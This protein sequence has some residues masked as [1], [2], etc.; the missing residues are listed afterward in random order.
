M[1]NR[2]ANHLF[3]IIWDWLRPWKLRQISQIPRKTPIAD[4]SEAWK[5]DGHTHT[6][7]SPQTLDKDA[8][9]CDVAIAIAANFLP[10]GTKTNPVEIMGRDTEFVGVP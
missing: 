6:A 4:P 9:N 10:A 3:R 7:P 2:K 1:R 5:C 8:R